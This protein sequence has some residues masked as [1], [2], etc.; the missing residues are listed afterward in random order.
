MEQLKL[1]YGLDEVPP[2]VDLI[3]LGLQ[4]FVITVPTLIIMGNVVA[5]LHFGNPVDQTIYIQKVFFMTGVSFLIQLLWGHQLPLVMGPSSVLLV[6]ITVSRSS[7]ISDIYTAIAI[8]GL[9]LFIISAAGLF[10]KI[11]NLFTAP[12]VATILILVAFTL[13]PTILNLITSPSAP[14]LA[15]LNL[16]FALIFVLCIFAVNRYVTGFWKSTLIMWALIVGTVVYLL[17][18]PESFAMAKVADT[19]IIAGF[20]SSMNF[21]WSFDPGVI[22]AFLICFLALS[23]NDLGSIY[24]VG[25]M[26]K[27]DHMPK[28]VTR[29]LSWTGILNF[30]SGLLGVIGPVNYSMSPGVIASTGCA[31]RFSLIPAGVILVG[32]SFMP[33]V[34]ALMG[35]IPQ[36]VVGGILLYIMCSQLAAGLSMVIQSEEGFNFE[37]G[38]VIGLPLMLSIIISFLP[39]SVLSTFPAVLRPILGN[40]F[41]VGVLV[42]LIMEHLIFKKKDVSQQAKE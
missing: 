37:K 30:F 21:N 15:L 19:G 42:V 16:L 10:N 27:P 12:V 5:A 28:R 26:L 4:W 29:G 25:G 32:I 33:P 36:V 18:F 40:G 41:V 13:T 2:I 24:S 34:I 39:N 31:S 3:F 14:E 7:S 17:I 22:I 23:I 38:L 8:G 9:V 6:G 35:A 20:F 11:K 1:K